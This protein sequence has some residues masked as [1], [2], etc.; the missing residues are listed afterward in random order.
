[1]GTDMYAEVY[2]KKTKKRIDTPIPRFFDN[3]DYTE[4]T[5]IAGVRN[6][7]SEY[8]QLADWDTHKVPEWVDDGTWRTEYSS[9]AVTAT[10]LR[11]FNWMQRVKFT[12][13]VDKEEQ[14]WCKKWNETPRSWCGGTNADSY[15]EYTWENYGMSFDFV[16][17]LNFW[18]DSLLDY[19]MTDD[20]L[21]IVMSFD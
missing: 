1:M 21:V 2:N 7:V 14:E 12:K 8:V 15:S 11:S 19:G 20:D 13:M 9:I 16:Q 5:L 3:R 6:N 10:E 17:R 18:L 4:Y